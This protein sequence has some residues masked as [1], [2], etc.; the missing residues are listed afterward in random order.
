[1]RSIAIKL[2]TFDSPNK[3]IL[4]STVPCP[5]PS[6]TQPGKPAPE[7][8]VLQ[9]RGS[10]RLHSQTRRTQKDPAPGRNASSP[11]VS[12]GKQSVEAHKNIFLK[13]IFQTINKH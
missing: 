6:P 8:T 2:L 3:S 13:E 4:S 1:M 9:N 7:Y 10:L 5:C 11:G 12:G